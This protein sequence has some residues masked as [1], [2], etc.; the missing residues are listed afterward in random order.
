VNFMK[1][2]YRLAWKIMDFIFV[3]VFFIL[4]LVLRHHIF[5]FQKLMIDNKKCYFFGRNKQLCDFCIDHQSCSRVHAALVWHKHLSRPFIID[6]GSSK[7]Y[8]TLK[9][10]LWWITFRDG[11]PVMSDLE[12]TGVCWLHTCCVNIW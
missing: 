8:S 7:Y 10:I 2:S 11:L 3:H 5:F 4:K 1:Q 12:S 6:L 9:D